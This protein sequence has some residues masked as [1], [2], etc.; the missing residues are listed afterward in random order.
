MCEICS[1]WDKREI[2]SKEAM[3]LIGEALKN[4]KSSHKQHYQKLATRILDMEVPFKATNDNVDK[5]F[6]K[7]THRRKR[8]EP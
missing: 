5:D 2:N 3:A 8:E 7:S 4:S 6:W 1:R